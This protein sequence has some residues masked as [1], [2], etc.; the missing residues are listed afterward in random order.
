MKA[1]I[2]SQDVS[3]AQIKEV[4]DA[5]PAMTGSD[6][7]KNVTTPQPYTV[8]PQGELKHTV[9]AI[10]C[11]IKTN[12]VRIFQRLG[13]RVHVVPAST[14]AR[15]ILSMAPDGV[16]VSNGPGDPAS[17]SYV[18]DTVKACFGKVPVFG[19]CLGHQ[20]IGLA[21]G[22]ETYKLKFGHHGANHPVKDLLNQR[23]G[24]TSQNHGFCVNFESLP[25]DEVE[26]IDLNLND[27]TVEGI[28]HRQWPIISYQH[29]PEA[30]PGPH[31][32][33]YLFEHFL[34]LM[35]SFKVNS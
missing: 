6:W 32:A 2:A 24:I 9:V 18:I 22:G 30:A 8:E 11:G 28:R 21:L 15:T 17:V 26:L 25:F 4:L 3:E 10:D 31:D 27:Q 14:D 12:I 35:E 20:I 34:D 5:T 7:V 33:Q 1:V 16:F 19:I 13:C 29:H 23:V